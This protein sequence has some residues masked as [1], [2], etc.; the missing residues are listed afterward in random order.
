MNKIV[1]ITT[2]C[3]KWGDVCERSYKTKT[4][5]IRAIRNAYQRY[6]GCGKFIATLSVLDKENHK[7]TLLLDIWGE[8]VLLN[9]LKEV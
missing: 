5:A 2:F 6:E 8:N 4:S 1:Y 7:K 3:L 9:K